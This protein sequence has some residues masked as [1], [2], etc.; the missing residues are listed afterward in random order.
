MEAVG[1]KKTGTR[2][3]LPRLSRDASLLRKPGQ[4]LNKAPCI[5]IN[6]NRGRLILHF[7]PF[8]QLGVRGTGGALT[9]WP[10]ASPKQGLQARH[11]C[12]DATTPLAAA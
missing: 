5:Q 2:G 1:S 3:S 6:S 12:A 10:E 7:N 8:F 4:P 11:G 9:F